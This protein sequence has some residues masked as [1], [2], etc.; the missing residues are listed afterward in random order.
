MLD[1]KVCGI[2]TPFTRSL[3][4]KSILQIIRQ[5]SVG[6]VLPKSGIK[7]FLTRGLNERIIFLP[8]LLDYKKL[9][10]FLVKGRWQRRLKGYCSMWYKKTDWWKQYNSR[11]L[12]RSY[13]T[14]KK[15]SRRRVS[16]AVLVQMEKM[17]EDFPHFLTRKYSMLPSIRTVPVSGH[18]KQKL[19]FWGALFSFR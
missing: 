10:T 13:S 18:L 6:H 7:P 17:A 4:H 15:D 19:N 5:W 11:Q 1:R 9:A 8:R 3:Y 16:L 14:E 12:Y 2:K